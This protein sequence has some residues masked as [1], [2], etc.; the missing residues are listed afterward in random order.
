MVLLVLVHGAEF[1]GIFFGILTVCLVCYIKAVHNR[2][3][4]AAS[5]LKC[6]ITIVKTNLG[7]GLIALGS[8]IGLLGYYFSWVWAFAG[9]MKLDVMTESISSEDSSDLSAVGGVVAF[10]FLL[11]FYWTHQVMKNVVRVSVSGVVGTW[12]FSPAEAAS[13]CSDAV[14]HSLVRSTT[15]SFGSICFGSLVAILHMLRNM[16][17]GAQNNCK[18]GVLKCI[19]TCILYYI[20]GLMEYVNKWAYIYVGLYGYGYIDA[21]RRV[22][23]LFKTRGWQTIIADNLVGRLLGIMSITIGLLTG[24]LTLFAAFLVEE[25]EAKE[26][27]H[28]WMAIGFEVGFFVGLILSGVFLNLILS[29]VDSVIVC[30]AEVCFLYLA[31]SSISLHSLFSQLI[32]QHDVFM[33]APNEL[34]KSHPAIAEEMSKTWAEAWGNLGGP[35]LVGLGGGLGIV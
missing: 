19:V 12:W 32:Y 20:D 28:G 33:Q 8:M 14:C 7:L 27:M 10:L 30:Y 25:F 31:A 9:T 4:Y 16:L 15:Y 18:L 3:P 24:V 26:D 23:S 11:S 35:V 17:Q 1:A 22:I 5:N 29:A 13:I 6:A 34:Q 2:I 21:G